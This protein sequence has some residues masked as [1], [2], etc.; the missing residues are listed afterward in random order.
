MELKHF[1]EIIWLSVTLALQDLRGR[2]EEK[3][4]SSLLEEE[5]SIFEHV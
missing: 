4:P 3:K 5:K 1:T 2:K